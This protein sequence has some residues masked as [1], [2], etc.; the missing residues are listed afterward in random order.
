MKRPRFRIRHFL[1]LLFVFYFVTTLIFQQ[2][3]FMELKRE[4]QKLKES[5]NEALQEREQ[6]EKELSRLN[7][8]SYIEK[9]AR[10][11]LRLVKPGEYIYIIS[12]EDKK[13]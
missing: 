12:D 1:L 9:I 6:L 4:E 8:K 13:Q 7:D 10:E 3:K 5:I 11:Q 2:L